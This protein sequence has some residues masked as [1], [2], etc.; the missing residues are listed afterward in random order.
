MFNKDESMRSELKHSILRLAVNLLRITAGTGQVPYLEKQLEETLML[1]RQIAESQ[2]WAI[3][4]NTM[5][6]A[7]QMQWQPYDEEDRARQQIVQS[8]LR[9]TAAKLEHNNSEVSKNVDKLDDGIREYNRAREESIKTT[10]KWL[11]SR[12]DER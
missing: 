4:D 6:N 1:A 8:A 5:D 3:A 7:L 2:R 10:N 11:K 9:I 12:R